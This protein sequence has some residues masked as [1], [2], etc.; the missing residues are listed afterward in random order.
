MTDSKCVVC[1]KAF[2]EGDALQAFLRSPEDFGGS[3]TAP[4]PVDRG[5]QKRSA[6]NNDNIKRKHFT[7]E[8]P[9]TGR[10]DGCKSPLREIQRGLK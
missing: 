2:K 3:W 5:Y 10:F 9:L 8:S 4:A 7:C 1:N 6:T